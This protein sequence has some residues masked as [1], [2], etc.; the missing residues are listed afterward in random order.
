ML[1][2]DRFLM[3]IDQRQRL[4]RFTPKDHPDYLSTFGVLQSIDV[5]VRVMTEVKLREDEY[6]H[7][8][9]LTSTI[10]GLSPKL[11]LATR[12]RRFL[13]QGQLYLTPDGDQDV[14][15]T[16]KAG[17]QELTTPPKP[18][19]KERAGNRM[20]RLASA[21]QAWDTLRGRSGSIKSTT[22]S[23]A[24]FSI[25]SDVSRDLSKG[26]HA[27]SYETTEARKTV[28]LFLLS[29]LIILATPTSQDPGKPSFQLVNGIGLSLV[30]HAE[31]QAEDGY[32][33]SVALELD[34]IPLNEELKMSSMCL[35]T[36]RARLLLQG[37][38]QEVFQRQIE[39]WQSAFQRCSRSTLRS[40]SYPT[41]DKIN[42]T[43]CQDP[44]YL[45]TPL[46]DAGLPVP[47]SPSAQILDGQGD[48]T[49]QEREE[50]GWWT[51][52]FQQVLQE[53]SKS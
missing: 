45:M 31:L 16:P 19:L 50:R 39:Q 26:E 21:V 20:S 5:I 7:I 35:T 41:A 32:S 3:M 10:R 30:F 40:L 34:L 18:M 52:R 9:D 53:M 25:R 48:S 2:L 6:D 14:L 4:L 51:L 38:T 43:N 8:K 23:C 46:L 49:Q 17:N 36:V 44:K 33:G 24:G 15:S 37:E 28:H 1:G 11:Q 29:D 27:S 22:S 42:Y 12:D 13:C 47:K